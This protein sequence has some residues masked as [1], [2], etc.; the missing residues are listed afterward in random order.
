MTIAFD[1]SIEEIWVPLVA[2][3]TLVPG[4]RPEPWSARN[5][6]ISCASSDITCWPA[7]RPCS[8]TI[9]QRPAAACASLLV[10]GEACPHNLVARWSSPGPQIL[11]TYGP[12]EATVTATLTELTPDKPVTI[13]APLPTYSIV[14]L[15]PAEAAALPRRANSARSASPASASRVGYLNRDELTEQK[16]IRRFPRH[17]QQPVGRIYRTGDLGRINDERRDRISR[18]ASTRR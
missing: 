16:F 17:R 5:S 14:I 11:N 13:G 8:S 2:G 7:A 3:A 9:E 15:D 6:P 4:A 10:G 18:A 1:F 12:T